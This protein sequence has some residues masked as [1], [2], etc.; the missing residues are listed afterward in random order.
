MFMVKKET[1][2]KLELKPPVIVVL[3]HVDHG[4]TT[5]IDYI[6]KTQ[7]AA[8]ESGGITQGIGAY[9]IIHHDKK[10]TFIDTPGHEAFS[11]IRSRG[12]KT[13][14]LAILIVA[15]D[16]GVMP[17][18]KEAINHIQSAKIPFIVAIN[19]VDK[20]NAQPEKI[21]KQ[22]GESSIFLEGYGGD[23]SSVEISAK[24][25]TGI[26]ELLDLIIL[27]SEI[28]EIKTDASL[29]ATGVIIESRFDSKK[30]LNIT[31]IVNDGTLTYGDY[32]VIGN[33][34]GKIKFMENF[35]GKP[36]KSA[37][38]STPVLIYGLS[39]KM[40]I[41]D[42]WTAYK[43]KGEAEKISLEYKPETSQLKITNGNYGDKK[44]LNII[45]KTDVFGSLEAVESIIHKF[46]FKKVAVRIIK[47][48]VGDIT[49]ED[50]KSAENS[51]AKIFGFKVKFLSQIKDVVINS[52]VKSIIT[53]V[54]YELIDSLKEEMTKI[55]P[56]EVKRIDL[57]QLK[58][59][60]T[61]SNS[62][63]G[64]IIGGQ[65]TE[66]IVKKSGKVEIIRQG[67]LLGQGKIMDVRRQ[68]EEKEE[69]RNGE[70]CGLNIGSGIKIEV[71]DLLKCYQ[72]EVLPKYLE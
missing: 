54:I 1:K 32:L 33:N 71:N 42:L 39:G 47:S 51:Q 10:M 9:E 31:A 15:A 8:K 58:V 2:K 64:M 18:T 61:F 23:V 14:D 26:K 38:P 62:R 69:A 44:V 13:A 12:A 43:N 48:G 40:N 21:K 72:E 60:A 59:L 7:V 65:V 50:L 46:D 30:G 3:G 63:E 56:V 66:G 20:S 4:K 29:N 35:L 16:D 24:N 68:K 45:L 27:I 37:P 17:Q 49:E 57:G 28:N 36:L 70:E 52:S 25:G 53:N 22:L 19:K 41:G 55:I 67:K 6:R 11:Q 34:F 5:L